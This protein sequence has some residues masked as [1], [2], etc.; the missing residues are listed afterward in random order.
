M[1]GVALL[2]MASGKRVQGRRQPQQK[3]TERRAQDEG[4]GKSGDKGGP[5]TT[6]SNFLRSL[7]YS[8]T[9]VVSEPG[10][11]RGQRESGGKRV[12]LDTREGLC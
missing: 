2:L 6:S 8:E 11:V 5:I 9:G 3:E 7:G 4:R 1:A 10:A 12:S